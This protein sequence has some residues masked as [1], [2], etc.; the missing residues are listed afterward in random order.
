MRGKV[1]AIL[2]EMPRGRGAGGQ[3]GVEDRLVN[4][5]ISLASAFIQVKSLASCRCGH[6]VSLEVHFA[7]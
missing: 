4:I 6:S 1:H 3:E 2:V 7:Q 5:P